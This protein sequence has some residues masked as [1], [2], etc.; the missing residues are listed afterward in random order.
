MPFTADGI[1]RKLDGNLDGGEELAA[2]MVEVIL[3]R[4]FGLTF[5]EIERFD[6]S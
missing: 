3:A 4:V 2:V 1:V 5:G 6:L